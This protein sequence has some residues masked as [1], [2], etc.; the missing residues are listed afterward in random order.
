MTV[1]SPRLSLLVAALM[2]AFADASWA[3]N[4]SPPAQPAASAA[5]DTVIITGNTVNSLAPSAAPLQAI[6]PTSVIDERFIRDGLRFNANYDDIVKY[7]PSVTVTSPEG[8]GLGKNEGIS[9]RGFQDGQ[10]NVTFDGIPF[11]DA[12]DFHHTTS[13]YFSNHVLGQAEVDR[14]PGGG[15]TIGNATFGGTLGL[16]TR[17]ISS[18]DGISP[19]LTFG[20]W[21]TRAGGVAV[22]HNFG[23]TG[24]FAEVSEEASDTFLSNTKDKRQ[25]LFLKLVTQASDDTSYSFVSS[26]NHETQN[27]VQGATLQQ[28]AQ[29]GWSFGLGTDPS[30]Q[31]YVGD[32]N[33]IYRST[34]NYFGLQTRL[35]GWR[36]DNKVYYTS[37]DH[38][39]NKTT[40]PTDD[41]PADNGVQFYSATG[42]K[43]TKAA[44]DVPG[45]QADNGFRAFGDVLRLEHPLGPGN[46]LVGAWFDRNLDS[47]YQLPLDDT[48]GQQTGT[49]YGPAY[50]YQLS[51]TTNSFQPYVQ[52]DWR[53]NR[54]LTLSPGLRYS[55][56]V[57][58]ISA[59]LDKSTPP[60]PLYAS[61]T[62]DAWLP[63]ISLHDKLNSHWTA[64][65]QIA[66]GYLA[67]PI[68]VI[69]ANGSQTLS[70]EETTNYQLG[71]AYATREFTFGADVYF[72]DFTNA[73]AT[74]TVAT[75]GGNASVYVNAGGAKYQGIEIEGT[76]A[77]N[78]LLSV[79]AN[80]SYNK[81]IYTG[82]S[83]DVAASPKDTAA[84]GLIYGDKDGYFGSIMSKFVGNQYGLDNTTNASGNTVFQNSQHIGGYTSVDAAFGYRSEQG[85]WQGSKGYSI[86]VD[87][88]NLFDS[89]KIT[90]FA[91]NQ[92]VSGAPL[93]FG[94]PGRG[95]FLDLSVKI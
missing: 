52:Y 67:P 22:D 28:I 84:L 15:A 38:W 91:G 94:L 51:D 9:I 61:A 23:N 76:Y 71:T 12:S 59:P 39:S 44:T 36:V 60:A 21:N 37:F 7:A 13:A 69:E 85:L 83:V 24:L 53:L 79:Y 57:R 64:Y 33:A 89:K 25:H 26:V 48:T 34:F 63:S 70:P 75:S 35:G 41:N 87:L 47:R 16:R 17:D 30:L 78:R 82:T 6:Q 80:A 50:N 95:V 32:N 31:T 68:N 49:K 65:A 62:Y 92:S 58:D 73:I 81:A 45:K 43:L 8:P 56:A 1:C 2:T 93:Y 14:G 20:S 10:F 46:L 66:K 11:G 54:D 72:I 88:N 5:S 18:V 29:H 74:T 86:S 42:K 4:G 19:Y 40:D 77:L 90:A 55:K 27:T 3:D